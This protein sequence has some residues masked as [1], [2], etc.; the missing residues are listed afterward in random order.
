MQLCGRAITI[1]H[2]DSQLRLITVAVDTK[3]DFCN[4]IAWDVQAPK[5]YHLLDKLDIEKI[6]A[7]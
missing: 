5:I 2:C 6:P 7:N 4:A 1:N 3:I